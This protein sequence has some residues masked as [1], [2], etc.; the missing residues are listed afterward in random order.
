ML[1]NMYTTQCQHKDTIMQDNLEIMKKPH[2]LTKIKYKKILRA[3]AL[4]DYKISNVKIL[5]LEP[6]INGF[7][8]FE[9]SLD[10]LGLNIKECLFDYNRELFSSHMVNF[11]GE[12]FVRNNLT[13]FSQLNL[14]NPKE[15]NDMSGYKHEYFG[16]SLDIDKKVLTFTFHYNL[17]CQILTED[18]KSL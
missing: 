18:F 15:I 9:V 17:F 12:L 1:Y 11:M 6:N 14:F 16:L 8:S 5:K 4:T 2:T 10:D 3:L 13:E 7:I